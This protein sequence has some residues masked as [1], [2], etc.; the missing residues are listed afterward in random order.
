MVQDACGLCK[1][2]EVEMKRATITDVLAESHSLIAHMDRVRH[3]VPSERL[4]A[5]EREYAK[6]VAIRDMAATESIVTGLNWRLNSLR[7]T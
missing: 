7:A 3:D 4:D 1:A 6:A 2:G 5:F